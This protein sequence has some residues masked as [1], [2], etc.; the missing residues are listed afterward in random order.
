MNGNAKYVEFMK[1]NYK[2]GFSYQE[3]APSFTADFFDAN[4]WAQLFAKSGA[5]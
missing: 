3:F 5:K 4:E 2:P 1:R